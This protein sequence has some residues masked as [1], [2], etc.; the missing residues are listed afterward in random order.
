MFSK[1]EGTILFALLLLTEAIIVLQHSTF[2]ESRAVHY[3]NCCAT[4][5]NHLHKRK[6]RQKKV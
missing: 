6:L 3:I 1:K 2:D 4:A 5:A